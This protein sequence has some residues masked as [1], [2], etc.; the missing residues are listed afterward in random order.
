[1]PDVKDHQKHRHLLVLDQTQKIII[2]III[3]IILCIVLGV[4]EDASW[5]CT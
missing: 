3:I 4:A 5:Y 1:V 2:I